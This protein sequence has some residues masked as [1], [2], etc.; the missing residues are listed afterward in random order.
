MRVTNP[1]LFT[2]MSLVPAGAIW[3]QV[4]RKTIGR[5]ER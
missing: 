2:M 5:R 4:I 3:T 1:T